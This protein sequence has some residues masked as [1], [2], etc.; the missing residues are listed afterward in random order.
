[1]A[2]RSRSTKK[3]APAKG[4]GAAQKVMDDIAAN[5]PDMTSTPSEPDE[6][7]ETK[8]HP[9]S[10][11]APKTPP[12][13]EP[14]AA[15]LAEVAK[16]KESVDSPETQAAVAAAR[17]Q[18]AAPRTAPKSGR[19]WGVAQTED[20]DEMITEEPYSQMDGAIAGAKATLESKGGDLFAGVEASDRDEALGI[21]TAL[22]QNE[23][24]KLAGSGIAKP[25]AVATRSSLFETRTVPVEHAFVIV[26]PTGIVHASEDCRFT[27]GKEMART[28]DPDGSLLID[29]IARQMHCVYCSVTQA[30]PA[31][32]TV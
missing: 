3:T 31:A 11:A 16:L 24:V 30:A 12:D 18:D 22:D 14:T 26:S 2:S 8:E 28:D 27:K 21:Y 32:A 9:A 6:E 5:S 23:R 17:T 15:E 20:G 29:A 25:V 4:A 13:I 10:P 1:M 7:R 19:W